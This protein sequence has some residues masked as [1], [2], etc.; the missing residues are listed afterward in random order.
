MNGKLV[1][2][3]NMTFAKGENVISLDRSDI[4]TGGV[5]YYEVVTDEVQ[6]MKKMIVVQ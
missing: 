4:S 5:Y 1:L 6:I 3:R 2:T